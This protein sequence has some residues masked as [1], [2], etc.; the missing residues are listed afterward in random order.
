MNDYKQ[1]VDDFIASL[2]PYQKHG[3]K[4]KAVIHTTHPRALI[5]YVYLCFATNTW[6]CN[7]WALPV[8]TRQ[9]N[10]VCIHVQYMP[11]ISMA[12]KAARNQFDTSSKRV[13]GGF[14]VYNTSHGSIS[15]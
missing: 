14:I 10:G 6:L 3:K 12:Q 1:D 15:R 5:W 11:R 7:F 13:N 2:T 9:K 4:I 8:F